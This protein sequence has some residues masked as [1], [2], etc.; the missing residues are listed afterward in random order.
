M[1][2]IVTQFEECCGDERDWQVPNQVQIWSL[3]IA[4]AILSNVSEW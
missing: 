1:G 3:N 4:K 2:L